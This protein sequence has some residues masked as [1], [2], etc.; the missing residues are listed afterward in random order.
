MI[1]AQRARV[2]LVH[3]QLAWCDVFESHRSSITNVKWWLFVR[4]CCGTRGAMAQQYVNHTFEMPLN[5]EGKHFW[6]S[7]DTKESFDIRIKCMLIAWVWMILV[8]CG[9]YD[10][11]C[12]DLHAVMCTDATHI[13]LPLRWHWIRMPLHED[14]HLR[15]S[16]T[17]L[18]INLLENYAHFI[19]KQ[20]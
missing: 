8:N 1:P 4:F 3:I 17:D 9:A 11:R 16:R 20:W 14:W 5:C 6:E 7:F 13:L 10:D 19:Q 2:L 12:H 15:K 18:T